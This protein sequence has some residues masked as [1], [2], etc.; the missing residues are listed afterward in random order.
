MVNSF[1]EYI[2]FL[3][4]G[5][6]DNTLQ[7]SFTGNKET[8]SFL[9]IV[10]LPIL[11]ESAYVSK[12]VGLIFWFWCEAMRLQI[13]NMNSEVVEIAVGGVLYSLAKIDIQK[14]PGSFLECIIK[15]EWS[16][17][18]DGKLSIDRDGELFKYVYAFL[19]CGS[20]PRDENGELTLG[21]ETV[22]ALK[23]EADFYG[24]ERLTIEC[25]T[26]LKTTASANVTSYM[27]MRKYIEY[28]KGNYSHTFAVEYPTALF[29]TELLCALSE[30]WTP[31]CVT[32]RLVVNDPFRKPAR[33]FMS[34]TIAELNIPELL[35]HATQSSFGHG[36]NTVTDT[37]VRNSFEIHASLLDLEALQFV[38][39]FVYLD[40]FMP[41][42]MLDTRP[43][44]LVIY[45]EGGHFD[46]HR[47]TV[48]GDGHIGTLVV[49]LNSEYTGGELEV[50]HGGRTEVVTGPYSWVAMYGDCLH[51]IN[52]VTSGTRV[53]LIYDIYA[54]Q[55]KN[56]DDLLEY[57]DIYDFLEPLPTGHR[58]RFDVTDLAKSRLHKCL[59][60]ELENWDT[61]L[62]CL[63]NLYT[64]YPTQP[65]SL[66]SSDKVLYAILTAG[67]QYEVAVVAVN[68]CQRRDKFCYYHDD[69]DDGVGKVGW[70]LHSPE[71]VHNST[72]RNERKLGRAKLVVPAPFNKA[73]LIE[74]HEHMEYVQ[75]ETTTYVQSALQVRR[76]KK[77]KE[78]N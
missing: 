26:Q 32:G 38:Q 74:Y 66:R 67:G 39:K 14:Y 64:N 73:G 60:S 6:L 34:S 76:K 46:A 70:A 51:K 13:L 35:N 41:N 45:K 58:K 47:D 63:E 48:R 50:T 24:L 36:T 33:L 56:K 68:V 19:V 40:N 10:K 5:L 78:D 15:K 44:K 52:P 42:V 28:V 18:N 75:D 25:D 17:G 71:F 2:Y 11:K 8:C 27:T 9:A 22:A 20:L 65:S 43:Y 23:A 59:T 4:L 16:Q 69:Y 62:I 57:L 21:K 1:T 30:V 77:D 53:S 12:I 72:L 29:T 37:S 54:C 55:D 7:W 31:F 3:D 49:I 61:I